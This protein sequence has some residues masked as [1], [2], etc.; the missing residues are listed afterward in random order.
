MKKLLESQKQILG[1]NH[2]D[3]LSTL[4][5]LGYSCF[6]TAK[7]DDAL[8]YREDLLKKQI[9][10]YGADSIEVIKTKGNIGLC[11]SR[12]T[13]Y[14]KAIPLLE[15]VVELSTNKLGPTHEVTMRWMNNCLL[16]TSPS[17]RD[18]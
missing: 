2:K 10:V 7:Y 8:V 15:N 5:I 18:S 14:V 3:T 13:D 4:K 17:P 12:K 11:F 16:Y 9:S 6:E 1:E